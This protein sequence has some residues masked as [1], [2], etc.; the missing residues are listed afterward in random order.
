MPLGLR[1]YVGLLALGLLVWCCV[2]PGLEILAG[3][4]K[5][6][7][8]LIVL[9]VVGFGGVWGLHVSKEMA[10]RMLPTG[11]ARAARVGLAVLLLSA[12]GILLWACASRVFD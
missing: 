9:G 5:A 2:F 11:W 3:N 7:A 4:V 8:P 6:L 10:A 1:L 12:W